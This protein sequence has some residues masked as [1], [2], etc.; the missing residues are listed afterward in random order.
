MAKTNSRVYDP[1][2]V[3]AELNKELAKLEAKSFTKLIEQI[4]SEYNVAYEYMKP[5]WDEWGL[6]L[7]LYNNQKRD[8][9]KVG[10]PL[11]FGIHQTVLASLY[12]DRLNCTFGPRER[13]DVEVADNLTE[14]AKFD[15]AEMDKDIFDYM[16]DFDASF[17]GRGVYHFSEFD[18]ELKH[19]IP[20][21]L[22]PMTFLRDPKATSAQGDQKGRNGLR[23]C[24]WEYR[25]SKR[26][27]QDARVYFNLGELKTVDGD[28]Y[29]LTEQNASL[30]ATAQ[31]HNDPTSRSITGENRNYRLTMWYTRW[32][33]KVVRVVLAQ[34]RKVVVRYD[35]MERGT[36]PI[37]DRAMYPM[38]HD[39]DGVSVP[40]IVEDKQRARSIL[41]NLGLKS[42]KSMLHPMYLFDA[43]KINNKNDLNFGFNKNVPVNGP[44]DNAIVPIQ[45]SPIQQGAQ[46]ILDLLD[47]A[48]QKAT[49]SPTQQQGGNVGGQQTATELA[50][51][52]KG[53]DA[54]YSLS[55]KV[56]GWS[57][58]RF[59]KQWYQLYKDNFEADIDEKVIRI[60]GAVNFAWRTLTRENI[61]PNTDPDVIIESKKIS[62]MQRMNELQGMTNYLNLVL[63]IPGSNRRYA[64]RRLGE[65]TGLHRDDIYSLLPPNIHEL[66]AE[67][68]N[69]KLQDNKKAEVD[70]I[71]DDMVHMEV[72][73]KASDTPAKYAHINAHKR[74]MMLKL[75]QPELAPADQAANNAPQGGP[76]T[77]PPSDVVTAT[78]AAPN[79]GPTPVAPST[80]PMRNGGTMQ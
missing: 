41:I 70:V 25:M 15:H 3:D 22:D 4:Q 66:K 12:D 35:V 47:V 6:R 55:A 46:F 24:G 27:M 57:E 54:R 68:E 32:N 64:A 9:D 48:A 75:L 71:D 53:V 19:P 14:M 34:D 2:T 26:E 80:T 65:L 10:D 76:G 20:E 62:D 7:K 11:L 13:G 40:D 56:F 37:F 63:A 52:N 21:L 60:V 16:L 61:I 49:A 79:T 58:K 45:R 30:R 43:N 33:G 39:W 51:V 74:A 72:H 5:K 78:S 77:A 29:S 38:S 59:W 44:V 8:K 73:N 36:I 23:F 69:R 1:T 42:A 67:E 18:R 50:I 31:G 28:R 17:F